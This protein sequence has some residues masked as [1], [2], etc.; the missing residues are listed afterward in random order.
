MDR[1][2][3][4]G[5]DGAT[6]QGAFDLSYLRCIPNFVVM[7]PKDENE[8]QHMMKTAVTYDKGPIAFRYPRG[9]VVGVKMDAELKP[10]PIGQGELLSADAERLDVLFVG[11]GYAVQSAIEAQKLVRA[12]GLTTGL[13]NARFAKPLDEN[14]LLQWINQSQLIVTVEEN[15]CLGGFGSSIL[16]LLAKHHLRKDVLVIGMPDQFIDHATPKTQR[17]LVM[18]DADGIA[19]QVFEKLRKLVSHSPSAPLHREDAG[20]STLTLN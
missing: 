7:A 17:E 12:E 15:T 11:I 19:R 3:L 2:G 5:A 18:L 16:E 6:H 8:L 1:A 13:I 20:E 10:I 14:L 9:E 4:V